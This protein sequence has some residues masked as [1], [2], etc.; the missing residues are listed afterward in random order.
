MQTGLAILPKVL[1]FDFLLFCQRNPAPCPVVDVTEPGNPEAG[2]IA[3]GSD[4]RHDLPRY[5]VYAKGDLIDEPSNIT[6]YWRDDLVGFMLGCSFTFEGELAD[7][8]IPLRHVEERKRVPIFITNRECMPAGIFRGNMAVTMRP[9]PSQMV[10]QAI[11]ITGAMPKA[12]GAPVHVG[13]PEAL[14]IADIHKPDFGDP[15]TIKPGEIPVFWACG[16]TVQV[17]GRTIKP[18]LL[19]TEAPAHMFITDYSYRGLVAKTV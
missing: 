6:K 5:R 9:I 15:V 3:P 17:L 2:Y 19:I 1:A 11:Q 14:G 4:I 16:V 7:H 10:S 18:E 12:H 13:F 8:G